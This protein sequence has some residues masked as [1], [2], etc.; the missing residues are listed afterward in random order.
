MKMEI[1]VII[2]RFS[3]ECGKSLNLLGILQFGSS[4]YSK[5]AKDV[6]IA[7]FSKDD[8]FSTE[9]YFSLFDIINRFESEYPDIIFDIAGG[10][11]KRKAKY[12]ITIVPL[13]MMDLN[14]GVDLFF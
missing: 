14:F 4:T 1:D 2:K 6:D 10:K 11:R 3:E 7:F 5:N 13:Q 9:D 12:P 8:V